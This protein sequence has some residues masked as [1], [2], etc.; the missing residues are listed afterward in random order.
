MQ[1]Y[2]VK[3]VSQGIFSFYVYYSTLILG[4][5]IV[6]FIYLYQSTSAKEIF[7]RLDKWFVFEPYLIGV[8]ALLTISLLILNRISP[9]IY[10]QQIRDLPKQIMFQNLLLVILFFNYLTI[11]LNFHLDV[12]E[13]FAFIFALWILTKWGSIFYHTKI[14]GWMHPTTH[15]SFFV[16]ALLVGCS[17]VSILSLTSIDTSILLYFLLILLA[18]DLFIVFSR[19]QYLSKFSQTT[20]LVARQLMGS[21]LLYFGTRIIIGIFMPAI[22]ILYLI[23]IDEGKVQEVE[24]LIIVGTLIDRFLFVNSV[25][26]TL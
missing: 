14:P 16:S 7:D 24:F 18:F 21:H 11:K 15:G 4:W 2:K 22:F 1:N 23:L 10:L 5:Q 25:D 6:S 12:F 20:N 26:L 13:L 19:F 8:G 17:L 3:I 9:I